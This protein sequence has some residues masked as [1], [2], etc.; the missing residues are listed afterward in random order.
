MPASRHPRDKE[1]TR[2]RIL[3]A[4]VTTFAEKGYNQTGVEDVVRASDTSK[5]AFYYHFS[6]KEHL[7]DELLSILV[8]RLATDLEDAIRDKSGAAN[9]VEAALAAVLGAFASDRPLTK[10][11]ILDAAGLDAER[12]VRLMAVRD[13]FAQIIAAQ[14][15]A[16]LADGDVAPLDPQITALVWV[17]AILEVVTHWL[18]Q[19]DPAPLLDSL[20][21]LRTALLRTLGR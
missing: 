19:D 20:P 9:K 10:I 18:R 2:Q 11:L 5:G 13:G 4:A 15:E 8:D 3:A 12:S 17:G 1:L 7:F 21:A 6:G 14:L 16:A